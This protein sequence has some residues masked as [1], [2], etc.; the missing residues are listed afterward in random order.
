[1]P[2]HLPYLQRIWSA[3]SLEKTDM[4]LFSRWVKHIYLLWFQDAG[5]KNLTTETR[6]FLS[7]FTA[8]NNNVTIILTLLYMY[9]LD[10]RKKA[11]L[12]I[13]SNFIPLLGK[14]ISR[15]KIMLRD[16]NQISQIKLNLG[17]QSKLYL[18]II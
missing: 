17:R 9:T 11:S 3:H 1:M 7:H 12:V 8:S 4:C 6:C 2:V 5:K 13:S 16:F 14:K 10:I 18:K 15:C